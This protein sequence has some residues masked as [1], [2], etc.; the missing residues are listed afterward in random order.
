MKL[1]IRYVKDHGVEEDERI[2]LKAL[3]SVD[4]GSYMLADTT[5]ISDCQ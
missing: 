1:A 2:I 3:G 4:I 5:Y